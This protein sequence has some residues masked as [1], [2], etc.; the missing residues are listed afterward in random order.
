MEVSARRIENGGNTEIFEH[1]RQLPSNDSC[2]IE[3]RAW[4]RK[5]LGVAPNF[6]PPQRSKCVQKKP[7]SIAD[8]PK[9]LLERCQHVPTIK[10]GSKQVRPPPQP[11]RPP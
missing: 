4:A 10:T 7:V 5:R 6:L 1:R 11:S 2:L 3:R 8:A 9:L